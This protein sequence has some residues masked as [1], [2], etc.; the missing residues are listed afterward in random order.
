[1]RLLSCPLCLLIEETC[2]LGNMGSFPNLIGWP[3][4]SAQDFG[5][6]V[7]A[8]KVS[9]PRQTR[10]VGH[11]NWECLIKIMWALWRR[12]YIKWRC[13]I[14]CTWWF[15]T[16]LGWWRRARP[17]HC[18]PTVCSITNQQSHPSGT[19]AGI[20]RPAV[21]H[22]P[23][24]L[25]YLHWHEWRHSP[26]SSLRQRRPRWS[27]PVHPDDISPAPSPVA[28]VERQPTSSKIVWVGW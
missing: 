2:S 7:L 14:N 23:P 9:H 22:G 25:G 5:V 12:G 24:P 13:I 20:Q 4:Q 1:M 17:A 11:S 26:Q 28:C 27:G 19:G 10:K 18:G 6:P 8:L 21:W 15:C 3:S 16:W